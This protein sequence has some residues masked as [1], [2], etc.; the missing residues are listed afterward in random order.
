MRKILITLIILSA[1]AVGGLWVYQNFFAQ[2]QEPVQERDEVSVENGTLLAVVNATGMVMPENQTTLA[3]QG[4]GRVAEVAVEEDDL[5]E[6][7][8]FLS[9]GEY[10]ERVEVDLGNLRI[11][12]RELG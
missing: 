7:Y 6:G 2:T 10:K 4:A 11:F 8:V 1:L 9:V 5:V 3:F 12:D